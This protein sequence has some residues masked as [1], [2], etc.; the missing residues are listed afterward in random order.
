MKIT[1]KSIN[2]GNRRASFSGQFINNFK[3]VPFNPTVNVYNKS[4]KGNIKIDRKD[5]DIGNFR[6]NSTSQ[7]GFKSKQIYNGRRPLFWSSKDFTPLK[8]GGFA[9]NSGVGRGGE[10]ATNPN[11]NYKPS[12]GI[13]GSGVINADKPT[14]Q[15]NPFPIKV[16]KSVKK[17]NR[18]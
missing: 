15:I 2:S 18:N 16:R 10:F 5:I 4:V 17:S 13:A 11:K 1:Q 8:V 9:Y 12:M 6:A 14:G 3:E 7:S